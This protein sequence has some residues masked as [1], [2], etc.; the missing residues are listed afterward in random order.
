MAKKGQKFPQV[1]YIT[2][3]NAGTAE[4][5][6]SARHPDDL[7]GVDESQVAAIYE[8]VGQGVISVTRSFEPKK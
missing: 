2:I 7:D 5:Y 1:I 3:E 4:E 8:I 6:L